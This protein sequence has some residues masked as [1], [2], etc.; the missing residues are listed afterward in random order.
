ML[1]GLWSG[2]V[3]VILAVVLSGIGFSEEVSSTVQIQDL[4]KATQQS[5]NLGDFAGTDPVCLRAIGDATALYAAKTRN[6]KACKQ[7]PDNQL[8]RRALISLGQLYLKQDSVSSQAARITFQVAQ[9]YYDLGEYQKAVDYYSSVLP[10]W[11]THPLAWYAKYR[12]GICYQAMSQAGLLDAE[13]IRMK[14]NQIFNELIREYPN[15]QAADAASQWLI[16]QNDS[17]KER[18]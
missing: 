8:Y 16:S 14:V 13:S 7:N 15:S 11:P 1:H 6:E 5:L 10:Y 17:V 2:S 12:L 4:Q 3:V 9:G 18:M